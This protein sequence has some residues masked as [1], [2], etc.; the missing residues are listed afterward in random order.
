MEHQSA[1]SLADAL[2]ELAPVLVGA[3]LAIIGTFSGSLLTYHLNKKEKKL[4]LKREKLEQLL[5]ASNRTEKW[6]SD[7]RNSKFLNEKTDLGINP[8]EEVKYLSALYF[9]ELHNEVVNLSAASNKYF[10]LIAECHV[11]QLKTGSIPQKFL[12]SYKPIYAH[13]SE[14]N[15]TLLKEASKLAEKL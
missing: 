6:L 11:E 12:E 7:Y 8:I 2:V 5:I 15:S 1:K 4:L 13:L 9:K 14:A 3:F 10:T